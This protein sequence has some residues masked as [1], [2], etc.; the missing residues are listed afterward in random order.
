MA[1]S[2]AI[3][4]LDRPVD[5]SR[6]HVLG[7]AN[8]EI[9]LVEFGSYDCPYCRRANERIADIRDQLGE[10]MRYTSRSPAA[11]SRAAPPISRNARRR[12]I[13]SGKRM[14]S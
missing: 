14:S 7:P 8:A 2:P 3:N 6:D 10:R 11:S 1:H 12:R 9:E 4:R 5:P 13:S